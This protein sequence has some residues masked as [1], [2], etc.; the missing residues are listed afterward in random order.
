MLDIKRANSLRLKPGDR[1]T[2]PISGWE[3]TVVKVIPVKRIA[4]R[5]RRHCTAALDIDWDKN[6]Q[7]GWKTVRSDDSRVQPV[8]T[9]P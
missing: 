6:V 5:R 8:R 1:V 7:R 4:D 9:L 3:G 2:S